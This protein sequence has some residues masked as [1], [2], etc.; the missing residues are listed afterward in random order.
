MKILYHAIPLVP[1]EYIAGPSIWYMAFEEEEEEEEK[2][3]VPAATN[4]RSR[5]RAIIEWVCSFFN[6]AFC[7]SKTKKTL[8]DRCLLTSWKAQER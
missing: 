5:Y 4:G 2:N 3:E 7:H 8:V 1:Y 6:F